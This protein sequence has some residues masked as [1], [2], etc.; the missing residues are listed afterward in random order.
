MTSPTF[1]CLPSG[2]NRLAMVPSSNAACSMVALS[3]SMS[4]ITCPEVTLSPTLTCH[5]TTVPCSMVSES[6]GMVTLMGMAF[7]PGPVCVRGVCEGGVCEAPGRSAGDQRLYVALRTA[8][9][10]LRAFG[11]YSCSRLVA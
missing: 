3:V 2:H 11:R 6:R 9:T 4:A 1:T 7:G 5:L 10:I 8:S